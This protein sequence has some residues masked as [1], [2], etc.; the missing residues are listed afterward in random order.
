MKLDGEL[1]AIDYSL[2]SLATRKSI[3]RC[4]TGAIVWLEDGHAAKGKA[5]K[6]IVRV[7]P[8]PVASEI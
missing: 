3:E 7:T 2:N 6:K 8:L 1:A 5:A 4:P